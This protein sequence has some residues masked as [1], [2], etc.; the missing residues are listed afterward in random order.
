MLEVQSLQKSFD[1]SSGPL[2]VISD[3]SFSVAAGELVSIV[4]P[5]GAGKTTLLRCISGLMQPTSGSVELV[6]S[7]VLAPPK[8]MAC[9]FQD[10]SRS[11][12]PWFKV[13]RNVELPLYNKFKSTAERKERVR[14]ALSEVG[15]TGFENSYPWQLSGGMQQRVAIARG[16]AYE[17]SVL[18]MDEPF[19]S[20][21]A[22]TRA[23]LE[24]LVLKVRDDLGITIVLVTHDIDEA[25]YLSDR[26]VVMS[27]RPSTVVEVLPVD[28]P[29]GRDQISTKEIP[30]FAELRS[31]VLTLIRSRGDR[32]PVG[33]PSS[34]DETIAPHQLAPHSESHPGAQP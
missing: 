28:L 11:L 31:H 19:A 10:Y 14:R 2:N 13:Q 7:P 16:L 17:P 32:E 12:F 15:L 30:R 24:D 34:S 23:D 6:G 27:A 25:V 21:D 4:G 26:V 33:P 1:T 20:V 29:R 8:E 5:S 3:V 9:V 22:Q 18:L